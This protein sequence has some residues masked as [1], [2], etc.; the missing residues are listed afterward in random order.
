MHSKILSAYF[1]RPQLLVISLIKL[2]WNSSRKAQNTKRFENKYCFLKSIA[3][4]YRTYCR[5]VQ[6]NTA[7]QARLR[8][9]VVLCEEVDSQALEW[10]WENG[11]S[12]RTDLGLKLMQE[13]TYLTR[14]CEE[15]IFQLGICHE[16][17]LRLVWASRKA[18]VKTLCY[19]TNWV[20]W[21]ASSS[22][23]EKLEGKITR[24]TTP[25]LFG[26][27]GIWWASLI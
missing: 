23:A 21:Q 5:D 8:A 24:Q 4:Y 2:S 6:L 1:Q 16:F 20:I 14:F 19:W 27:I 3:F 9:F 15:Y 22:N 12:L 13:M 10:I 11:C 26:T 7:T 17:R 18:Y 25:D